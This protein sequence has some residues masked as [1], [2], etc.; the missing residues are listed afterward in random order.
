MN[1]L[2][3]IVSKPV[4]NLYS[5]KI[6]GT[7][8]NVCFDECYKKIQSLTIFDEEEEE[9]TLK[10]NKIYNIGK[11][12][13]VI[14]NGEALVLNINDN[15][16]RENNPINLDVYSTSGN[17]LGRLID[18]QLNDKFEVE[19]FITSEQKIEY[20][21]IVN[22]GQS[23]IVNDSEKQ[24]KLCNLKP[25]KIKP[26]KAEIQNVTIMPKISEPSSEQQESPNIEDKKTYKI[27]AQ[28][29]PQKAV[30]NGN[31]LIGRK[32]LKTIYGVNNEIIIKKDTLINAKNLESAKKHS[33]LVE[34][35]VFS[36]IKA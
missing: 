22:V 35:T 20:K 2:S 12:S 8:K 7:V 1:L 21:K 26:I 25:R 28:P 27:N 36:K 16:A 4:L 34:L 14:K 24:V 33:K 5:G 32:A 11:N 10:A 6:E 18:A 19:S 31:F 13:I 3:E 23:I 17:Y 15:E 30:G 9:Y 29:L